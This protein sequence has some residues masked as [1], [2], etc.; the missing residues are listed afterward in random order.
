M[1]PSTAANPSVDGLHG[2]ANDT[3]QRLPRVESSS[4]I[5]LASFQQPVDPPL[6]ADFGPAIELPSPNQSNETSVNRVESS[7][8]AIP[9]SYWQTLPV[10][11]LTRMLEF[12]SIRAEYERHFEKHVPRELQGSG[13]RL[14]LREIV[15]VARTNS[16]QYQEE[17][18]KLY[19]AALAVSLERYRFQLKFSP[20]NNG[21]D[22]DYTHSRNDGVTV[23]TLSVPSQFQLERTL[24]RSGTVLARFANDVLLTFNGPTGFAADV[25]SEMLFDFTQSILQ[26]DVRLESLIQSER[27]LVYAARDFA[28]FRKQF[29]FDLASQYYSILREYRTIEINSQNYFSLV[30]TFEQAKAEVQAGVQRAPNQVAVDQYEQGMLSGRSNLIAACNSLERSLDRLKLS[31]GMPTEMALNLNLDEL[32][33]LTLQD[34]LEVAAEQARRWQNRII[35]HVEAANPDPSEITNG[36]VFLIERLQAWLSVL[37]NLS[38]S[39]EETH[40]NTSELDDLFHVFRIDQARLEVQRIE[41]EMARQQD[42][43]VP[44]SIILVYQHTAELVSAFVELDRRIL[45][46]LRQSKEATRDSS[47]IG[48][49]LQGLHERLDALQ[50]QLTEILRDPAE[51]RL[52]RLLAD[53]RALLISARDIT[54]ELD[55]LA[56]FPSDEPD[57]VRATRILEQTRQLLDQSQSLLAEVPRGLPSVSMDADDALLTAL[58]QRLDLMNERGLLADDW[59]R[60]KLAADDLKSVL[61]L[62]ARH[63]IRTDKNHPFDFDFD[64]S[65]TNL[66]L[67]FDL[68][69][70]RRAQR[71]N[72]RRALIDYQAGRR[73]LMQTEDTI[74]FDVRDDLRRLEQ[75]RVQYPISVTQ[76]ALAAEQVASIRLQLALGIAG[77]RGTDLLDALQSSRQALTAVA[78]ARIGYIV[79]RAQFVFDLELLQ[80][81]EQGFWP[82]INDLDFQPLPDLIY[83]HAAGPTYGE[84]SNW[85]RPSRLLYHIYCK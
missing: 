16:R 51:Q 5:E 46:F 17:K 66:G 49:R 34:Q 80:L 18:E 9:E 22:V 11:C 15:D 1:D 82:E 23:N 76:A 33:R 24:A 38:D 30:R 85:V 39:Q 77:V 79:D 52:Q 68:P 36:S 75:A 8:Q 57:D 64:D 69:L 59:R 29:F 6:P 56:G 70:N 37:R 27:S 84:I 10:P 63:S 25:S 71:N 78:N 20:A 81:D 67:T 58:I 44:Q 50:D 54:A 73:S 42:A 7:I 3:M 31:M 32:E 48:N 35:R 26:R 72:Y 60:I 28:R 19:V 40:V 4:A 83:P 41:R 74:K 12:N 62:N 61:N 65:Q 21:V 45:Q 53:S 47:E 14:T 55:R 13:E 43:A 2:A